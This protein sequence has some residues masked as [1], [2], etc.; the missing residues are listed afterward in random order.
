MH[1]KLNLNHHS[2]LRTAHTYVHITVHNSHTQH[3]LIIQVIITA[4]LTSAAVKGAGGEWNS[5]RREWAWSCGGRT[6]RRRYPSPTH[7]PPSAVQTDTSRRRLA[8]TC[9]TWLGRALRS[10]STWPPTTNAG[11]TPSPR[12]RATSPPEVPAPRCSDWSLPTL[13]SP[14]AI[15]ECPQNRRI[16]KG[17]L[18]HQHL[19]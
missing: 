3:P 11:P 19:C 5:R 18:R 10:S 1:K 16:W 6:S 12:S 4:P 7:R 14:S 2:S 13:E 17:I 9:D 15:T 8:S